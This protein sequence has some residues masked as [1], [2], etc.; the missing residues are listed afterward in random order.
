ML[1]PALVEAGAHLLARPDRHGRLH[2]EHGPARQLGQLVDDRPD[3][4][5]V[6]VARVGRRRADADEEKVAVG[7]V[8]HVERVGQALGVPLH[9]LGHVELVERHPPVAQRL[10]PLG[11]D[12]A[13]HDLVAEL[14]EADARDEADP[15]G[16][17]DAHLAHERRLYPLTVRG[18]RPFAIASIVSFESESSS[19]LTTQ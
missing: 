11:E 14:G 18:F 5:Q 15:A 8:A 10:D 4:R 12:V 19:V 9:Q 16:A 6:G 7:D 3:A 17:E 13:D 2:H 1:E